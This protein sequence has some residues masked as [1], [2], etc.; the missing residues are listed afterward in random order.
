MG[1]Y[2]VIIWEDKERD[3]EVLLEFRV[4]VKFLFEEVRESFI[5]GL[6]VDV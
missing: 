6:I 3:E 4:L 1:Y 2:S 5:I